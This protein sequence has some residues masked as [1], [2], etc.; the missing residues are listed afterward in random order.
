MNN[1]VKAVV[2]LN[3]ERSELFNKNIEAKQDDPIYILFFVYFERDIL[4]NV[5]S[6]IARILTINDIKYICFLKTMQFI[7]T[8]TYRFTV[9]VK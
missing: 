2:K 6:D 3:D 4:R 9:Y 8:Y 1:F 7:C 5:N